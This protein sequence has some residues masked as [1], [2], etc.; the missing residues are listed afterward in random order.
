MLEAVCGFVS[1]EEYDSLEIQCMNINLSMLQMEKPGF[2]DEMLETIRKYRVTPSK[3]CIELTET[4]F[5][6]NEGVA[7]DNLSI[8]SMAGVLLALDDYGSGYSNL[9][10]IALMPFTVIKLDRSLIQSK[11]DRKLDTIVEST[12]AM[13]K[14]LDLVVVAEGVET[15]QQLDRFIGLG[16]DYVQGYYFAKPQPAEDYLGFMRSQT[17]SGEDG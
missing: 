11:D 1:S 12:M 17:E 16:V 2:A 8:L 15:K 7:Y 5:N 10:T 14:K 6:K 9:H 3:I 4:V 13:L